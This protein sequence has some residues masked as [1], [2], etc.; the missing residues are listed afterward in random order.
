MCKLYWRQ[1]EKAY[2]LKLIELVH[3]TLKYDKACSSS[4]TTELQTQPSQ[5]QLRN[6]VI[7][8]IQPQKFA[9]LTQ[10]L[11]KK[12]IQQINSLLFSL[13]EHNEAWSLK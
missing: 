3:R 5:K 13:V 10:T 11:E 2:S 6:R 4:Q 7:I 1:K 12:D 8:Y 9:I